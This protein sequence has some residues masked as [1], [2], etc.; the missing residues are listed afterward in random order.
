MQESTPQYNEYISRIN[1]TFDFIES[2]L[3]Q[4]IRLEELAAVAHFSKFHFNRIF[5]AVVGETPFQFIMRLRLERAASC[6]R[7]NKKESISSIAFKCGFSDI[8]IFSRNF[9]SH[10]KTSASAYRQ[11]APQKSNISQLESNPKQLDDQMVMYFCR[12]LQTIKWKTKMELIKDAEVKELP[13]MTVAYIR[14]MGQYNG[15]QQLFQNLRSKLFTWAGARGLLGGSDFKFMV[16]YHDD[17]NVAL[18]DKLRMSLCI[19]IPADTRVEGEIGKME[20]E[21]TKY[22]VARF[23]LKG[24]EFSKAWDW[25]YGEWLPQ[26]GYQPDDKPYFEMYTQEPKD[27]IYTIEFCVPVKLA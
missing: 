18:S 2:K 11:T 12:D 4:P 17:P 19:T 20:I 8:A 13:K 23:E 9:K 27:G 26:S 21:R 15:D 5:H 25:V 1:K 22:A 10:F 6:I 24:T 7:S 3:D 16:L 14:N